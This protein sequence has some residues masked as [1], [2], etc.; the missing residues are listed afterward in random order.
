MANL[1]GKIKAF[2][3]ISSPGTKQIE[4]R[5][6]NMTASMSDSFQF[7]KMLGL[8]ADKLVVTPALILYP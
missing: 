3:E 5:S 7:M 1:G 8:D 4:A 2:L 6:S